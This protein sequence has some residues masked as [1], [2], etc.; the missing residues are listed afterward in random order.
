MPYAEGRIVHDADSHQKRGS[1]LGLAISRSIVEQHGGHIWAES[2]LG[3]GTTMCVALSM[4][5]Q[6]TR[7]DFVDDDRWPAA[8]A[9]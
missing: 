7:G 2:T 4:A 8:A 5:P 3:A 1:G 6:G 9:A